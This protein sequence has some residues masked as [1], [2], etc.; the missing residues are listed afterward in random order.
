MNLDAKGFYYPFSW[1]GSFI[2]I[3]LCASVCL[4]IFIFF[5][6]HGNESFGV[7]K[8][9]KETVIFVIFFFVTSLFHFFRGSQFVQQ[10]ESIFLRSLL[11][12][13]VCFLILLLTMP[14]RILREYDSQKMD[15]YICI[16]PFKNVPRIRTRETLVF[17]TIN[18]VK[19]ISGV[20]TPG[21]LALYLNNG[22]SYRMVVANIS[23][24]TLDFF[25]I[26]LSQERDWLK[27]DIEERCGSIEAAK[28]RIEKNEYYNYNIYTI[29]HSIFYILAIWMLLAQ[30][31]CLIVFTFKI[32][33]QKP[34][35]NMTKFIIARNFLQKIIRKR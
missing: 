26:T 2:Y 29:L 18:S 22:K 33:L 6:H 8:M 9:S 20:D 15:T 10:V 5:I 25:Y 24:K 27:S 14:V 11:L 35:F 1:K 17:N 31:I 12:I 30:I 28:Q 34:L 32:P 21:D 13:G 16:L 7:I 4:Y 3:V 19:Y 23:S